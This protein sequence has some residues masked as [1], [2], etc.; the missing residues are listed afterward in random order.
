MKSYN[1]TLVQLDIIDSYWLLSCSFSSC[2]VVIVEVGWWWPGGVFRLRSHGPCGF[3]ADG[4]LRSRSTTGSE[5]KIGWTWRIPSRQPNCCP[6]SYGALW[7]LNCNQLLSW[8]F[9][10]SLFSSLRLCALPRSLWWRMF[11]FGIA[12]TPRY[13]ALRQ[14]GICSGLPEATGPLAA[15]KLSVI[16]KRSRSL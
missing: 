7:N 10:R 16:H 1:S 15:P 4:K 3:W 13:E 11:D 9:D 2:R 6:F 5:Q 12:K 8:W 14:W